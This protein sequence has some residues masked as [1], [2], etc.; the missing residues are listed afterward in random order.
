MILILESLLAIFGSLSFEPSDV[1]SV[2]DFLTDYGWL[3]A[4]ISSSI[5]SMVDRMT[6]MMGLS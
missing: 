2:I 1:F 5:F 3:E 6:A 4:S